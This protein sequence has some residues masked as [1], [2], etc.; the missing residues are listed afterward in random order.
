[1]ATPTITITIRIRPETHALLDEAA[2]VSAQTRN[3]IAEEGIMRACRKIIEQEKKSLSEKS[4]GIKDNPEI[5]ER[6]EK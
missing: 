1:M 4:S 3:A 2:R 5:A 6:R